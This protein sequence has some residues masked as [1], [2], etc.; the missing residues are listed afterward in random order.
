[1]GSIPGTALSCLAIYRLLKQS[2]AGRS[3]A[4]W[5]EFQINTIANVFFQCTRVIYVACQFALV[6]LT[7]SRCIPQ[8]TPAYVRNQIHVVVIIIVCTLKGESGCDRKIKRL[9]RVQGHPLGLNFNMLFIIRARI[10]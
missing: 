10:V 6:Q 2:N 3:H 7:C 4:G 9:G 1:M 5:I 8:N